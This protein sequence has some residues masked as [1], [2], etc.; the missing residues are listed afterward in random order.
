MSDERTPIEKK[1]IIDVSTQNNFCAYYAL[2][3]RI[4]FDDNFE[5]GDLLSEFNQFYKTSWDKK[6]LAKL[7]KEMHPVQADI[8][9]GLVIHKI[10]KAHELDSGGNGLDGDKLVDGNGLSNERLRTLCGQFGYALVL[11]YSANVENVENA[12]TVE[13]LDARVDGSNKKEIEVLF[14]HPEGASIG[15]YSLVE[16]NEENAATYAEQQKNF[17]GGFE[18]RINNVGADIAEFINNIKN[19]V[20][21][22]IID[23]E[24]V[25]WKIALEE[26]ERYEASK[27]DGK[28]FKKFHSYLFS[29]KSND[30]NYMNYTHEVDKEKGDVYKLQ[31]DTMDAFARNINR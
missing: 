11:S 6:Q 26:A 2:A 24:I 28:T 10:Y 3:R 12:V 18:Y 17:E 8:L 9:L 15:H 22:I 5:A 13:N 19:S 31:K 30:M 23:D 29:K 14:T 16:R 21:A 1:N 4:I 20:K 27:G 25:A 7:L